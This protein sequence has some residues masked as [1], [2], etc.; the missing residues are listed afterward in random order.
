MKTVKEK[1]YTGQKYLVRIGLKD[2]KNHDRIRKV[3][4]TKENISYGKFLAS[5]SVHSSILVHPRRGFLA[6]IPRHV[7]DYVYL[8][9]SHATFGHLTI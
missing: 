7:D 4:K 3:Y 2:Y 5:D 9:P 8:Y 1:H 6:P